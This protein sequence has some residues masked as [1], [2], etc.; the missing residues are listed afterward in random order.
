MK[1]IFNN[2][3]QNQRSINHIVRYYESRNLETPK[4]FS[5]T[6]FRDAADIAKELR[7]FFKG[8][9]YIVKVYLVRYKIGQDYISIKPSSCEYT[10]KEQDEIRD[11]FKYLQEQYTNPAVI[12]FI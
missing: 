1:V 2:W 3:K 10:K 12:V 7:K 4:E 8:T 9:E 6:D 11:K 5:K